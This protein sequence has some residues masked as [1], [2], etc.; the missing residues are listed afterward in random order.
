MRITKWSIKEGDNLAAYSLACTVEAFELTKTQDSD[1]TSRMEIELID[2]LVVSTLLV[3]EGTVVAVG[4]PLAI[5]DEDG[6]VDTTNLDPGNAEQDCLW[7]A[8]TASKDDI[9]T[10]GTC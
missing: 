9:G 7:Q 6:L 8:Y 10:C 1:T 2:E 4:T 5:L 3:P